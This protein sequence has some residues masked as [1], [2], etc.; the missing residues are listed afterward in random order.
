[1]NQTESE[2][3]KQLNDAVSEQMR[4][5]KY[6]IPTLES[7]IASL[8]AT[9]TAQPDPRKSFGEWLYRI[10]RPCDHKWEIKDESEITRTYSD[11]SQKMIGNLYVLKCKHCGDI[12]S[13]KVV[14]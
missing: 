10:F 11:L 8:G 4:L 7:T 13:R 3:Q 14:V 9:L 6:P 2:S 1:M 5:G 12:K